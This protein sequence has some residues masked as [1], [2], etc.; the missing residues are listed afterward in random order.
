MKYIVMG[1]TEMDDAWTL[2][3]TLFDSVSEAGDAAQKYAEV[4]SEAV[5]VYKL[6]EVGHYGPLGKPYK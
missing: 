1:E 3:A 2:E 6:V 4:S 5:K